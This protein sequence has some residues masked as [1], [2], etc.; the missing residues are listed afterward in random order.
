MAAA[1]IEVLLSLRTEMALL[2]ITM[3][4][5][6]RANVAFS[7]VEIRLILIT[8]GR[9]GTNFITIRLV[10]RTFVADAIVVVFLAFRTE[11][12]GT[13]FILVL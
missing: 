1:I 12:T 8:A 2:I 4:L 3:R 7:F 9:K 11:I 5:R 13:V 6:F 10:F